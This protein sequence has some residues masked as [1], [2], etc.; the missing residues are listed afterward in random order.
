MSAKQNLKRLKVEGPASNP[1][2]QKAD[3]VM[4]DIE[5]KELEEL[6]R[7]KKPRKN[8]PSPQV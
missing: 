3:P 7:S 5:K 2:G 4:E 6:F 1:Y 8:L